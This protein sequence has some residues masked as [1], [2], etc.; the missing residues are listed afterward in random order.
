[1]LVLLNQ[2]GSK[3]TAFTFPLTIVFV[4]HKQIL[5]GEDW[6]SVMYSGITALGGP[7]SRDGILGSLYFILL[8]V[9][10]NCIL[11][12]VT[13]HH[14]VF[15][16]LTGGKKCY[17]YVSLPFCE[18]QQGIFCHGKGNSGVISNRDFKKLHWLLLKG[19]RSRCFR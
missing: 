15:L 5:T 9:L 4:F 14:R 13:C 3:W 6:N 18:N 19:A 16:A 8:V 7:H 1:M 12:K 10:G 2:S 11:E 17:S